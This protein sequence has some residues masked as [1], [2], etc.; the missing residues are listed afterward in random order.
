MIQFFFQGC[1]GTPPQPGPLDVNANVILLPVASGQCQGILPLTAAQFQ[2][3]GIVIAK[4][5]TGPA[6]LQGVV[7]PVY[8]GIRGFIQVDKAFIFL[9]T[10]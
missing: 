1:P 10:A 2:D 6:T 7:F 9:E 4:N 5:I 8:L 3:Y